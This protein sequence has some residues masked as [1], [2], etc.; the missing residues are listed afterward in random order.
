MVPHS[1]CR[2][3][4][5]SANILGNY[6]M[7]WCWEWRTMV[8]A[9]SHLGYGAPMDSVGWLQVMIYVGMC[10]VLYQMIGN[11]LPTR[12]WWV[13]SSAS[14]VLARQ[15][16][17]QIGCCVV[18]SGKQHHRGMMHVIS[19]GEIW[20]IRPGDKFSY[21]M[22]LR[23]SINH[24]SCHCSTATMGPHSGFQAYN[25]QQTYYGTDLHC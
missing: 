12:W 13:F 20:G 24:G 1:C 2:R 17:R 10:S 18:L 15:P 25:N 5:R 16:P 14:E 9:I 21:M 22:G 8:A 4:Q 23:A 6:F 7:C 19:S 11:T 3:I